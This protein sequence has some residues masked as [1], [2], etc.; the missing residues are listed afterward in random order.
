LGV[1]FQVCWERG[2]EAGSERCEAWVFV[3]RFVGRGAGKQGVRGVKL[4]W[5]VPGL[6]G[7][8]LGSRE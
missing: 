1:C 5:F 6:L 3:S 4:G 7:E 8:G 2:W